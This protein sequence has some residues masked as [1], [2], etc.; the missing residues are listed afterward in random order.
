[1]KANGLRLLFEVL[2]RSGG[3]APGTFR[4]RSARQFSASVSERQFSAGS[5]R[6]AYFARS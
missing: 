4:A 6:G 2:L 1:M 5:A 3:E